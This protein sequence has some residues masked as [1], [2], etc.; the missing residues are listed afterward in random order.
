MRKN[1]DTE[2]QIREVIIP[3]RKLENIYYLQKK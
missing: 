2:E 3:T 1:S